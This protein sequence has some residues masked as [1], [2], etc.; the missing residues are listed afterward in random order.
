MKQEIYTFTNDKYQDSM[1]FHLRRFEE[2]KLKSLTFYNRTD[3]KVYVQLEVYVFM[4]GNND[5]VYNKEVFFKR[6]SVRVDP[7]SKRKIKLP[8]LIPGNTEIGFLARVTNTNKQITLPMTW[9]Y[10]SRD[11][12]LEVVQPTFYSLGKEIQKA[13]IGRGLTEQEYFSMWTGK[14]LLLDDGSPEDLRIAQFREAKIKGNVE[15]TGKYPDPITQL[16]FRLFDQ[17]GHMKELIDNVSADE[18][19]EDP[20]LYFY[21]RFGLTRSDIPF[22]SDTPKNLTLT[23]RN[24]SNSLLKSLKKN[25][26]SRAFLIVDTGRVWTNKVAFS[27]KV[28]KEIVENYLTIFYVKVDRPTLNELRGIVSKCHNQ[29][30]IRG[31]MILKNKDE[32]TE[33]IEM[34][35]EKWSDALI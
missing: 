18:L 21:K 19:Y 35:F 14:S 7:Q 15:S 8:K 30:D 6:N 12:K 11:E 25:D 10:D 20:F 5:Y 22:S 33:L 3:K 26:G 13:V 34:S 17:L 29:H 32:V 31:F 4:R 28:K 27:K 1:S 16:L 24:I 2:S 23:E 9:K